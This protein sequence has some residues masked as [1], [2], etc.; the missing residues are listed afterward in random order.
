MISTFSVQATVCPMCK[1]QH[2]GREFGF[3]C[4]GCPCPERPMETHQEGEE[5]VPETKATAVISVPTNV[6]EAVAKWAGTDKTRTHLHQ[7]LFAKGV[8]VAVDG[9]RMV[10][11]P[12]ETFGLTIGVDR[13][14]LLAA[15]A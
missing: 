9:H 1:H 11:V 5:T 12:C 15:V 8:M 13:K 14:Y 3:I 6:L 2:A 10:I 7:V 4:V